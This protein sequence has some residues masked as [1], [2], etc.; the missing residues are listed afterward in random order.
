MMAFFLAFIS[1]PSHHDFNLDLQLCGINLI[2]TTFSPIPVLGGRYRKFASGR[3]GLPKVKGL[4]T[5][6]GFWYDWHEMKPETPK[7]VSAPA[8][9]SSEPGRTGS[10]SAKSPFRLPTGS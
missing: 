7:A 5:R 3:S 10:A 8:V 6:R 4:E 1:F 9:S 2:W